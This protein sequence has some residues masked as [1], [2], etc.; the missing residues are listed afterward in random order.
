MNFTLVYC[1]EKTI[2]IEK[3]LLNIIVLQV[4]HV[5]LLTFIFIFKFLHEFE[6]PNYKAR[7]TTIKKIRL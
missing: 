1:I 7:D 3:I 6:C 2:E 4:E 5:R